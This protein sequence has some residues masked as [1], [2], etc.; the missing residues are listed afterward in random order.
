MLDLGHF[1]AGLHN[2]V[3]DLRHSIADLHNSIADLHN[4]VLDLHNFIADLHN[5]VLDLH[6]FVLDLRHFMP[7]LGHSVAAGFPF[8]TELRHFMA[9]LSP[10]GAAA[11][12]DMLFL[13]MARVSL[14][15]RGPRADRLFFIYLEFRAVL[16]RW[17]PGESAVCAAH[18]YPES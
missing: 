11:P 1:I 3:L 15:S 12:R 14:G 10:F 9:E 6:N 8:K 13:P 18:G 5:F 4:F 7:Y 17:F 16:D 2:S